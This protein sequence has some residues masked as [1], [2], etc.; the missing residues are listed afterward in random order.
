MTW[1]CDDAE[2]V[3]H[4]DVLAFANDVQPS[5][6]EGS[7]GMKVVDAWELRHR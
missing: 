3:G 6:L 4:H 2:P 7:N 5:F 1:D